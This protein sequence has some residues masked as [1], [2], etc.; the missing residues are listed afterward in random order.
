VFIKLLPNISLF[1]FCGVFKS[2]IKFC[3]F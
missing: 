2:L 1:I 3:F